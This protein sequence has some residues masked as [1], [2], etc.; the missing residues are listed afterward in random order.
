M[1]KISTIDWGNDS[2]EKDPN[3]LQYFISQPSLSRLFNRSKTFII[4]RKG[5]GKSAIRKRLVEGFETWNDN[6]IIEISPTF[7][8]FSNLISDHDIQKNFNQEVFFQYVW[9]NHLYKKAFLEIGKKPKN[10]RSAEF[11]FAID[12]AK[13]NDLKDKNLLES[14]RD[15]LNKL[16]VKA[17]QLGDLGIEIENILRKDAEIDVYEYQ[18]KKLTDAGYKVTWIV[19]DLDLGWNNSDIANNL[20]LGLLTCTNYLKN[21]SPNLHVFICLREDV[22]RILLT[23]TQHSD[24][25]R[26]IEKIQWSPEGLVELLKSRIIYNCKIQNEQIPIEPFLAVFP[27]TVSTSSTTN[28]LFERTLG[29]PRELIQLARLYS[30]KNQTEQPSSEVLKAVEVEYSNWKLEDLT[31]EYSNQFPNLFELFKFWRTKFFRQKYHLKYGEFS[32]MFLEMS[33]GLDIA[34]PWYMEAVNEL[35]PK[36]ILIILYEIGFIGDFILG[37]AGGSKTIYSFEELHEPIF[38]EFQ[39]HP[40]FRKALGTVERIRARA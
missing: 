36:K 32:D 20:L 30:E 34:S 8:I 21:I 22:Y 13:A 4:G 35:D 24:K 11:A 39:I 7:N 16:K 18:L 2:A 27:E 17:G 31:T 38:E 3:L 19:D 40:C 14:A 33:T 23:H 12:F 37:G 9:L 10:E 6:Y 5:A 26:D 25:Y 29:R 1:I 28:W 15:L